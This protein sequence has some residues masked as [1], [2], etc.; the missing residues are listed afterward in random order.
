MRHA[1]SLLASVSTPVPSPVIRLRD[2]QEECI[3]SVLSYLERGH[4]RLG[5]SLATGS[6]KTVIFTQ[7][8]DRIKPWQDGATQTL[9][10]V[11]RRELVEQAARHCSNAYPTKSI[12]IEMG[13]LHATGHADITVASVRSLMSGDRISKF[14]PERFKLVLVD[15]AHH[16]AASSYMDTLQHFGIVKQG[17]PKY[18][19]AL[20][21][22]SATLSRFDGI[23]LSDAIDHVVYHKDYIDMIQNNWLSNV[24]FTT[25]Q[26][27]ADV[28]HVKKGPSGDFR[29]GELSRAVNNEAT[30]E[31]TVRAWLSKAAHRKST[32]VFCVDLA[33]VSA[34]TAAFRAHNVDARFV[35]G[36]TPRQVRGER[37]DA[38]KSQE[39]P[40]L[41]N[42]G[43][44]TEGTDIPN[45]DCVLLARPTKSRNLLVQMIGRGMRLH[46]RKDDCHVIDM[47]A[48]LETGIVTTPTL[49]GL[50]PGEIVKE[51][52]AEEMKT[53][54]ERKELEASHELQVAE[55]E[56]MQ[57]Q[58]L[59]TQKSQQSVTFT[60]YDSVYDLIADTSADRHI[61][62][63]SPLAWVLVGENRYVLSAQS[64]DYLTIET[65]S[66]SSPSELTRVWFIQ[67]VPK[68]SAKAGNSPFRRPRQI[69]Q[70]QTF[71]D[72]VHAA[73]T[74]ASSRFPWQFVQHSQAWRK[75]PASE[76]Q[77]DFLNKFR[78]MDDKLTAGRI[79]KGKAADL[80]TKL[81]FGA[82]GWFGRLEKAKRKASRI[83]G[84]VQQVAALKEREQVKVGPLN[85]SQP[86][87]VL[88]L[89]LCLTPSLSVSTSA[90]TSA[91]IGAFASNRAVRSRHLDCSSQTGVLDKDSFALFPM[92]RKLSSSADEDNDK[93]AAD[94]SQPNDEEK[95][96]TFSTAK[97]EVCRHSDTLDRRKVEKALAPAQL[98]SDTWTPS[99]KSP[100]SSP[101]Q[102]HTVPAVQVEDKMPNVR[103]RRRLGMRSPWSCSLLTVTATLLSILL[104]LFTLHSFMTRQLDSKG[105]DMYYTRSVFFNFADFDTE[106]TRF[107]TKYSLHLYREIGFD[108]DSKVKGV[109]VLFI[110]GNAGSYRQARSLASE[111]VHHYYNTVQQDKKALK[112]GATSIDFFSVDFNEDFTA[113]HGQ[114]LLDQA[115]YLNDAVAY[116][117]SLYHDPRRS[118][119]DP[120]LP[121]PSSV[122]LIGHSMGGV[123]ART[124]LT[125]PNYQSNSVNTIITMSAPHARSPVS[126]DAD[127]VQTYQRINDHWRQSYSQ[128]WASDNPLWHVTLISIAGG[129]LDTTVPSDYASLSSLVP[130]THG[131]TVFTSSIPGMWTGT[132]HNQAV[133]CAQ[134]VRPIA[135][136][137]FEAMDVH[138]PSQTKPR[139]ERMRVFKRWY[140]TGMEKTAEKT[141]PHKEPTTLLTLEDQ[142][143]SV[144]PTG[145]RLVLR[146]LGGSEKPRA[147]VLPIP[148]QGIPGQKKFTLLANLPLD[149]NLDGPHLDVLF[150]SVLPLQPGHSTTVFS[151]DIDL[152][153]GHAGSTRLACKN[154]ASDRISLPASYRTS[155]YPFDKANP[156]SYLQYDLDDLGEH[157]FVAVIDKAADSSHAWAFA[158]FSDKSD[159]LVHV[160]TGLQRLLAFGIRLNL[161]TGRP[162]VT[163]FEI[164]ALHSSLLAFKLRMGKQAC[165][166]EAE[167]FTPLL[168]QYLS[169]PHES[170]F[171]VNVKE[172]NI[173]LHG[174]APFMPPPLRSQSASNGLS[175]QF[176]TDP[177]CDS[178]I[179][180]LLQ[181]DI[182]GSLGKLVMRYRTVFAAFP[183][184]IVALVLRKQ[185]KLYDDSGAFVTFMES[186]DFCLRTSMPLL[187]L[188]L[189]VLAMSLAVSSSTTNTAASTGWFGR[190]ANSTESA[191]DFTKNDLLLGSQDPIFWF[192]VPMFGLLSAGLCILINYTALA[193]IL[194]LQIALRIVTSRS[195]NTKKENARQATKS[196]CLTHCLTLFSRISLPAF[197]KTSP[198]RRI[199][200]ASVLL[201]LVSTVIPY[202]FAYLVAC[203][204]QLATCVRASRH[205]RE[206]RSEA[207]HNFCNY[208]HSILMLMLCILP[209][210]IPVLVVWIHNLA[211]HWL[212]PFSSHHNVLSIMPFILLVETLTSGRI[213]PRTT[214]RLTYI[215]NVLFFLIAVYAAVYGISYAYLLHHLV[216]CVAAW[217]V[218]LHFSG[219]DLSLSGLTRIL[220]GH[221]GE[222][223]DVKKRP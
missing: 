173:S 7:L 120:S 116:I 155:V 216:N 194:I 40:V 215:T 136:S 121:D 148:P 129:T 104:M 146:G 134:L 160:K 117:L 27:H 159:S 115:E 217:L 118:Q 223:R 4:K 172:A 205:A 112:A 137:I 220:E 221:D 24:I 123:A 99:S 213:V 162:L 185:F 93:T 157:Q 19:P 111:T 181:V 52:G 41:L 189:T 86:R 101:K 183:L 167:L 214:T 211:V 72:A 20:V 56:T 154:A 192:L 33:H 141:L 106:H 92:R 22:V 88:P 140:L 11:H 202:Q 151:L 158:E 46:P 178:S 36:D 209:I 74:F 83:R 182:V 16:I 26:S 54:Q 177:T 81:K 127:L 44:F 176:W 132:D 131:F 12:E 186:M 210:N 161:P 90:Q 219:S 70:S 80:I 42:C 32:I 187:F 179:D 169:E 165:G 89:A 94:T 15:E 133:W 58:D 29:T 206:N 150:C 138:R 102:T 18:A 130:S 108:E 60:D 77:L 126:V 145:K 39:F 34:L 10:L 170:R 163:A 204:V 13:N 8:I 76:G 144:N 195:P 191:I 114:T 168:R 30:N 63:M 66:T 50:D 203:I 69:A 14:D 55:A 103:L 51:L 139:A 212:T 142:S 198:K 79:T 197:S 218:V 48:S 45:I 124:M 6:G 107:A 96:K 9:I 25:V 166:D 184:L 98:T 122:I 95:K 190:S 143:N 62:G 207:D 78:D 35:T 105:C 156:F 71:A 73:D 149:E 152:S 38:F 100:S 59:L 47:V 84:Q 85:Q 109:P 3:Q 37:L 49:F 87:S 175:L 82:K 164:P 113:F 1:A 200:T 17:E 201:L 64:G 171:F 91:A 61:R 57:A 119:R 147:H 65:P 174:I 31:T 28:S 53:L 2:Y 21:G 208:A 43:V 188:A 67:K 75:M 97:Y 193:I 125:M 110:P 68:E 199:V 135:R 5:V 196:P 153:D 222:G 128:K 180:I 23:R